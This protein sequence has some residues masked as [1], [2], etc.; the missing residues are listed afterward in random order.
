V[1]KLTSRVRLTKRGIDEAI[2]TAT[3][4]DQMFRDSEVPGL[5]LRIQRK[6]STF[7]VEKRVNG[8]LKKMS[9]GPYGPVTLDQARMR[10]RDLIGRLLRG[11]DPAAARRP[12]TVGDLATAYVERH[13]LP[14]KRSA[15]DD[16]SMIRNYL[17]RWANRRL[18]TVTR[19]DIV[20]LH[21]EL[22]RTHPYRA[23]RL[24]ALLHKMFALAKVWGYTTGDNPAH[25]IERFREH[26]RDRYLSPQE[27]P[28]FFQALKE[29]PSPFI[30][31][32]FLVTLL[33]GVRRNEALTM[34]WADIDLK[35]CVAAFPHT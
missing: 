11:E 31:A 17:S 2:R 13:A 19:K 24:L 26:K 10:G 8:H 15:R 14:R 1:P 4:G 35:Q 16:V 34:Q 29:E 3:D 27:L 22:G 30:K 6:T 12:A 18:T 21:H 23:N 7:L 25:G 20:E 28:R 5:V 33:L 9:I 32:A